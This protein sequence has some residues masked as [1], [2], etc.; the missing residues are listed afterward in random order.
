MDNIDYHYPLPCF[1]AEGLT[2][3]TSDIPEG[4]Y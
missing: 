1:V 2:Y 3:F 4:A